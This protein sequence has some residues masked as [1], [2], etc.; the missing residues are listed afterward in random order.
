MT[1]PSRRRIGSRVA[2]FAPAVFLAAALPVAGQGLPGRAGGAAGTMPDTARI[3]FVAADSLPV[4][5]A[6]HVLADTVPFGGE[7]AVAWDLAPGAA[8]ADGLPVPDDGQLASSE[9]SAKPWWRPWGAAD[10]AAPAER[11]AALPATDGTRVVA[12]YRVYRTDPFRLDWRGELSHLV[13]VSG[14]VSDPAGLAAIRDPRPLPWLT[15]VALWLLPLLAALAALAWR[16]RRRGRPDPP[17]D[18]PLPE[19]AWLG[20]A[21]ALRVL[22][23]E[24]LLER[25]QTRTFLDRLAGEARRFAA[26][27]FGVPAVDLT[28]RELAAACAARGHAPERTAALARLLDGTD[29]CRYDPEEPHAHSCRA[30]MDALLAC[31]TA[32][33]RPQPRYVPVA[34]ERRLAA[35]QA[36]AEI[37]RRWSIA[38][39]AESTGGSP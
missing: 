23:E 31:V 29:L 4:P 9:P 1:A 38:D 34:A 15:P 16:W 27:Q 3:G 5:L 22:L 13:T 26:A 21:I 37:S 28:G 20:T 11:L 6:L 36:W 19:P 25:G 18:W 30:Q 2:V 14:R 8:A 39:R 17:V 10:A 7:L 35:E 12:W 32:A 33:G 24:G